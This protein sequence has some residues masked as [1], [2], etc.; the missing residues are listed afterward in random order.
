IALQPGLSEAYSGRGQAYLAIGNRS[1]AEADLAKA[2]ALNPKSSAA[3]TLASLQQTPNGSQASTAANTTSSSKPP[4]VVTSEAETR[5]D[6]LAA[7]PLDNTRPKGVPGVS[8]DRVNGAAAVS[9]CREALASD[10]K[11]GRLA[12]QLGRAL[13]QIGQFHESV[14]MYTQAGAN[15]DPMGY[16]N[17][18]LMFRRGT[19][20]AANKTM[21]A[22]LYVAAADKGVTAAMVELGDMQFHGDGV[23]QDEVAAAQWYKKAAEGNDVD[24]MANWGLILDEGWGVPRDHT[25]GVAWMQKAAAL[26]SAKAASD[27]QTDDSDTQNAVTYSSPDNTYAPTN[28]EDDPWYKAMQEDQ[29]EDEQQA[30]RNRDWQ[31]NFD[32]QQEEQRQQQ[33]NERYMQQQD[34][35]N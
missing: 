7:S 22:M 28:L 33:E 4:N 26:G 11:N 10:P 34:G 20:I 29:E 1:A 32:R 21:A 2:V 24:G 17:A 27:L 35:D 9:P 13:Q 19:G 8:G 3:A 5:C 18:G 23:R 16:L 12:Y 25:A 6:Q 15:G 31:E 30:Q 14:Q